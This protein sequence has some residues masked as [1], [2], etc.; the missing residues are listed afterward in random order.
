LLVGPT[1]IEDW[2]AGFEKQHFTASHS[3]GGTST[4]E[5]GS[6]FALFTKVNNIFFFFEKPM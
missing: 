2:G 5:H 6:T 3:G 1:K 4:V